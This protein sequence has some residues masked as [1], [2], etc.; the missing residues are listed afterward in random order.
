MSSS[1]GDSGRVSESSD[2]NR[3]FDSDDGDSAHFDSESDGVTSDDRSEAS[4]SE[5]GSLDFE[6]FAETS[7]SM[8]ADFI[9]D[10]DASDVEYW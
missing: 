6:E 5:A 10:D 1:A 7:E 3:Q 2:G 9:T 8:D 4:A